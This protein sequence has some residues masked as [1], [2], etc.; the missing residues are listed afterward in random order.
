MVDAGRRSRP[1][2]AVTATYLRRET[3]A[4]WPLPSD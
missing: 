2:T 1:D 3:A 4:I